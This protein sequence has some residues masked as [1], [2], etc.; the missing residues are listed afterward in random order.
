MGSL[1][2]VGV[3][4]WELW[5]PCLRYPNL[6]IHY[7]HKLTKPHPPNMTIFSLYHSKQQPISL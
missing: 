4:L 6:V 2:V 7:V 5:Q 1:L 3:K